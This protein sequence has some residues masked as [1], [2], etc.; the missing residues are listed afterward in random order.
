MPKPVEPEKSE[1]KNTEASTT[2][3]R[4]FIEENLKVETP[5]CELV[6]S[7]ESVWLV[8]GGGSLGILV[9]FAG[10]G[11]AK[12]ITA[13]S[14]SPKDIE[15][16]LEPEIGANSGRAFFILKSISPKKGA[17]TVTFNS[18]CG[19]KEVQVRVR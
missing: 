15:V 3:P 4:V 18:P 17:F 12:K 11:D 8:N 19:K 2:R 6:A 7:Q 9:G 10:Q 5:K 1:P 13:V 14:S 16:S